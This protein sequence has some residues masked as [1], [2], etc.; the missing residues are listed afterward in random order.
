MGKTLEKTFV[1]EILEEEAR[2]T[3]LRVGRL[4]LGEPNPEM[5]MIINTVED[6]DRLRRMTDRAVTGSSWTEVVETT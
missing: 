1:Q 2:S 6:V 3:L 4:R 5:M